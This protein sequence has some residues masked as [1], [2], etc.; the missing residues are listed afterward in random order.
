MNPKAPE[1]H[2]DLVPH[3]EHSVKS[4][5]R[6]IETIPYENVDGFPEKE[7]LEVELD[8]PEGQYIIKAI[9][10]EPLVHL[11]HFY[12][13][14]AIRLF[15]KGIIVKSCWISPEQADGKKY[16]EVTFTKV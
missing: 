6:D 4:V 7:I 16:V 1:I 11:D 8:I 14:Q 9:T 5:L 15:E 10:C 12:Q 2:F 3:G 13:G